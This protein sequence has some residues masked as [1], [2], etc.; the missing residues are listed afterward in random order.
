MR[1]YV[2]VEECKA[3]LAKHL[4]KAVGPIADRVLSVE[5]I[6]IEMKST[7]EFDERQDFFNGVSFDLTDLTYRIDQ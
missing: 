5:D 6:Q 2:T 1:V 7:G 3:V 4:N